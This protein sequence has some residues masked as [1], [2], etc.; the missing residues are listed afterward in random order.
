MRLVNCMPWDSLAQ[1]HGEV[2][3][4]FE[5]KAQNDANASKPVVTDWTPNVDIAETK[6][7]FILFLDLPG[8]DFQSVAV[9]VEDGVLSIQGNRGSIDETIEFSRQERPRGCFQRRFT[10]PD[11]ADLKRISAKGK[12]GVLRVSILKQEKAKPQSIK[13]EH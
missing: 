8:V 6:E 12:D 10:L 3:R 4:I 7:E 5:E 2:E 9:M 13:I 1:L 11:T